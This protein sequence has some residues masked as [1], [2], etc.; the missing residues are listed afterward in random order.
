MACVGPGGAPLPAIQGSS[1]QHST[2]GGAHLPQG[3]VRNHDRSGDES[4]APS[5][6]ARE[7]GLGPTM[8]TIKAVVVESPGR[9]LEIVVICPT[10]Q[11]ICRPVLRLFSLKKSE[12]GLYFSCGTLDC[13]FRIKAN[14]VNFDTVKA[15][16]PRSR[17]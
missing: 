1:V 4:A 12:N 11:T 9:G 3:A 13:R 14:G 5:T 8:A 6:A 16:P 10:C 2:L 15:R 7:V 17:K